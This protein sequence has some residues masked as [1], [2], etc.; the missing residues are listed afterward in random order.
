MRPIFIFLAL[1]NICFFFGC[2]QTRQEMTIDR[3][4]LVGLSLATVTNKL[5]EPYHTSDYIVGSAPTRWWNH[6]MIIKAY[7][8]S[9][10]KNLDVQLKELMWIDGDYTIHACFHRTN[11][12]WVVLGATRIYKYV[13]F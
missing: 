4:D 11:D 10:Q 7:P 2:N 1:A 8:I 13:K 5:G 9:D 6:G 3:S 12:T